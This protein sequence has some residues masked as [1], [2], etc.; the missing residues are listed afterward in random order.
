[1]KSTGLWTIYRK[2]PRSDPLR[3]TESDSIEAPLATIPL[4]TW[5]LVSLAGLSLVAVI[6]LVAWELF[7]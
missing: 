2:T 6:A 4:K 5:V 7:R 3:A 1:M